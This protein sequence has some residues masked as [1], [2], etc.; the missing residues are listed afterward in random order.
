MTSPQHDPNLLAYLQAWRQYLEQ[1]ASAAVSPGL[2]IPAA[3]LPLSP[4][5]PFAPPG[6]PPMPPSFGAPPAFPPSIPADHTQQLLAA[7]QAWR[8]YLEHSAGQ[9][10]APQSTLPPRPPASSVPSRPVPNRLPPQV[11]NGGRPSGTPTPLAEPSAYGTSPVC[12]GSAYRREAPADPYSQSPQPAA[13]S[14][15]SAAAEPDSVPGT[16][17]WNRT[18]QGATSAA[19]QSGLPDSELSNPAS[20]ADQ[21]QLTVPDDDDGSGDST[22]VPPNW[23]ELIG[24]RDPGGSLHPAS[25]LPQHA[26][27]VV[28]V[29]PANTLAARDVTP[30]RF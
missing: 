16:E 3:P 2:S 1:T 28:S 22:F 24:P 14:L 29:G 6:L 30:G 12:V 19:S 13:R 7:L 15:Y 10:P 4:P 23:Q 9:P 5:I 26:A 25:F 8:Q 21:T 20:D 11:D 27:D 18:T 17:W